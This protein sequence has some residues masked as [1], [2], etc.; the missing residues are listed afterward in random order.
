MTGG[1]AAVS[2]G[3]PIVNVKIHRVHW[4]TIRKCVFAN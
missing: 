1:A 4:Q 2:E 3:E